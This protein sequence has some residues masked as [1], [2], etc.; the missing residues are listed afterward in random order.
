MGFAHGT[1][2]LNSAKLQSHLRPHPR[3][4]PQGRTNADRTTAALSGTAR[5]AGRVVQRAPPQHLKCTLN[6]EQR[7]LRP[8][9]VARFPQLPPPTP[10][11]C[12]SR[13]AWASN[14]LFSFFFVL[15]LAPF[16]APF[17]RLWIVE[18]TLRQFQANDNT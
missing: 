1:P 18:V 4:R 11:P 13:R 16:G 10:P 3:R 14:S 9:R 8:R 7:Q 6:S 12:P 15:S 17:C 2:P 5:A